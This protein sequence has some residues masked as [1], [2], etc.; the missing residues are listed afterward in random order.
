[1]YELSPTPLS[2]SSPDSLTS[3]Q[4]TAKSEL[5]KHLKP[6]IEKITDIP[7]NTPKVYDAMVLFQKLPP[8]LMTFGDISDYML[9]KIMKNSCSLFFYH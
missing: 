5:F 6:S 9:I 4:K 2:L 3:L 8:T 1:M 7:S